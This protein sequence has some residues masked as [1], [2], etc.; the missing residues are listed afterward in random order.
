MLKIK[1]ETSYEFFTFG[2]NLISIKLSNP[3]Y[4]EMKENISEIISVKKEDEEVS[5]KFSS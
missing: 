5:V 4:F 2:P 1:S 3:K